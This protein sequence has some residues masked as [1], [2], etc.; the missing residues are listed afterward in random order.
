LSE[1]D[2]G[3]KVTIIDFGLSRLSIPGKPASTWSDLPPEVYEGKGDQWDVYRSMRDVIGDDWAGFHPETNVLVC[4]S[5]DKETELMRTVDTIHYPIS[6]EPN[7]IIEETPT[8]PSCPSDEN[9]HQSK[10][11]YNRTR[12][13]GGIRA[14]ERG[15]RVLEDR[16]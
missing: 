5:F 10:I 15:R 14:S 4:F 11:R 7:E 6:P 1:S 9:Q 13:N 3:V 16:G 12:C 2:T 8:N